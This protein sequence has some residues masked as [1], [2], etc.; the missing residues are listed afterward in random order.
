MVRELVPVVRPDVRVVPQTV[1]YFRLGVPARSL[2]AWVHFGGAESGVT[3]GLA[4]LGRDALKAAHH[5]TQGPDRIP[6]RW[7]RL[8]TA[9]RMRCEP[10][11][12]GS[13][14]AGPRVLGIERCLYT[15]TPTEDFVIDHWPG[16]PRV[17]FASACSGHGFKFAPLTGRILAD[18]WSTAG[19]TSWGPG[20]GLALRSSPHRGAG[21]RRTDVENA[22]RDHARSSPSGTRAAP[23]SRPMA[24]GQ[25]RRWSEEK[26][27]GALR[28]SS[29]PLSAREREPS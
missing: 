20:D 15:M 18:W 27:R 4:E 25:C 6:T 5:V 29:E 7:P 10:S 24:G 8:P 26:T 23:G 21:R 13:G 11:S 16:D 12:S 2:P 14:G 1:E 3:Y 22:R 9:R 28:R 17:A 19:P